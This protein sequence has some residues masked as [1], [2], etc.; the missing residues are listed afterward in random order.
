MFDRA[1]NVGTLFSTTFDNNASLAKVSSSPFMFIN[2]FMDKR[3]ESVATVGVHDQTNVP[4]IAIIGG[5]IAGVT[6]ASSLVKR[7]D[8]E[9][10]S[11]KIVLF[12]EDNEGGQRSVS[13]GDCQQPIWTAGECYYL[14]ES[15]RRSQYLI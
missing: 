12:E 4:R 11:A 1:S 2:K 6:A 8:S 7:L 15:R 10:K 3:A 5:G 13:F 9:N 14:Y